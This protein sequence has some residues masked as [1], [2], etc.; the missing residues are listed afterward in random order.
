MTKTINIKLTGNSSISQVFFFDRNIVD[1]LNN[2]DGDSFSGYLLKAAADSEYFARGFSDAGDLNVEVSDGD[3]VLYSGTVLVDEAEQDA[4]PEEVRQQFFDDNGEV[5]DEALS[6]NDWARV[7]PDHYMQ[8]RS[9]YTY[10]IARNVDL[11]GY[12][13]IAEFNLEV[14]NDFKMSDLQVLM[15]DFDGG[16]TTPQKWAH[17]LIY[18]FYNKGGVEAEVLGVKYDDGVH[19]ITSEIYDS[20]LIREPHTFIGTTNYTAYNHNGEEW[21]DIEEVYDRLCELGETE[22]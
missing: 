1:I 8:D 9:K 12:G 14:S 16:G 10:C 11:D 15:G 2:F 22:D 20:D 13:A 3:N 21:E 6:F 7:A 18:S 19:L 4:S 17:D 5:Y